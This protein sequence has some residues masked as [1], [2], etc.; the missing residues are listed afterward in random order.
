MRLRKGPKVSFQKPRGKVQGRT[1][2]RKTTLDYNSFYFYLSSSALSLTW[3][4]LFAERS[5]LFIGS[6]YVFLECVMIRFWLSTVIGG[7]V[8]GLV[9]RGCQWV[10]SAMWWR[11]RPIPSCCSVAC[12]RLSWGLVSYPSWGD[13]GARLGARFFSGP[14]SLSDG[15]FSFDPA[16]STPGPW[17]SDGSISNIYDKSQI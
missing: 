11:S 15:P 13:D 10:C 4:P 16:E 7:V 8:S 2:R 5:F 12:V 1:R 17:L 6:S 14:L 9:R 3:C